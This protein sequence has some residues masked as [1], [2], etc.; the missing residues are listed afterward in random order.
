MLLKPIYLA[1]AANGRVRRYGSQLSLRL[2]E[3]HQVVS[4]KFDR[5]TFVR[6]VLGEQRLAHRIAHRCLQPGVGTYLAAQGANGIVPVPDA[7]IVPSFDGREAE[8]DRRAGD[9]VTP[10]L[11]GQLLDLGTQLAR[12]RRGCQQPADHG[13]AHLRPP[14]MDSRILF[15]CHAT[16]S[17]L[18]ERA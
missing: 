18:V 16:H 4:M 15:A 1:E 9:R 7:L 17:V 2:R 6:R 8:T 11:G 10:F 5:P 14:L 3:G 13:K 12:R